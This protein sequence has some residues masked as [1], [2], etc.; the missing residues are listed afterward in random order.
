MSKCAISIGPIKC[1]FI[2]LLGKYSCKLPRVAVLLTTFLFLH[3]KINK[4]CCFPQSAG[5]LSICLEMSKVYETGSVMLGSF[6]M[7]TVF[8]SVNSTHVCGEKTCTNSSFVNKTVHDNMLMMFSPRRTLV[9]AL[10]DS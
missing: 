9:I 1:V 3:E 7:C 5:Y 4:K 6:V 10:V 2:V 8:I